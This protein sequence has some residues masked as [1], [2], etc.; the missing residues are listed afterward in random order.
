MN[1]D[2]HETKDVLAQGGQ[3][4]SASQKQCHEGRAEGVS[5]TP[6]SSLKEPSPLKRRFNCC[7]DYLKVT[8]S[9]EFNPH[10]PS[11]GDLS[12]LLWAYRADPSIYVERGGA[13][14]YARGYM[15]NEEL[16]IF[17]GGGFTKDGQGNETFNIEL[18][19]KGCRQF[20]EDVRTEAR[21]AG[22]S[23]EEIEQ[24][25][26]D[27]WKRLLVTIHKYKGKCT[28]VDIPTDDFDGCVP[29]DELR[30]K[31]ENHVFSSHLRAFSVDE[32]PEDED[33]GN[34]SIRTSKRNGW[35]ATLGTRKAAQLCI[36]NKLAKCEAKGDQSYLNYKSWIRY[37]VRY[38]HDN[39]VAALAFLATAY[40]D[41]DPTAVARFIVGCLAGMISIKEK[42]TKR[43]RQAKAWDKWQE[44]IDEVKKLRVVSQ[45]KV[46]STV[47]SNAV[48]L[49]DDAAK[50][51]ARLCLTHPDRPLDI[52]FKILKVGL[53]RLDG[54]DLF[55]VNNF[56][57]SK[58]NAPY[59]S[60][61]EGKETLSCVIGEPPETPPDVEELFA[62]ATANLGG[63]RYASV[64]EVEEE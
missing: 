4:V 37:E 53:E 41:P 52:Y 28:R 42:K 5:N 9:G 17:A 36:Y 20:E 21:L 62:H 59:H 44:F 10:R 55:K 31:I 54:K 63:V 23:D 26:H 43:I 47:G 3:G 48:W 18:K 58:G 11:Y 61:E 56:L 39:A 25:V 29:F 38:Y 49:I 12:D 34:Y 46:E 22:K 32:N 50:C 45:A 57:K 51:F 1:H 14:G 2:K 30:Q 6:P 64:Q 40:E 33:A 7:I 24:A 60:L 19:G 16:V 27:A 35:T 13:N 8:F 15:Y